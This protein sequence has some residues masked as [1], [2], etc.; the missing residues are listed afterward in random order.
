MFTSVLR[1]L[2]STERHVLLGEIVRVG[3]QVEDRNERTRRGRAR[4][5][6]ERNPDWT[7]S[8]S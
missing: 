8:L 6:S 5:R 4:E 7:Q 2:I 1:G 3:P